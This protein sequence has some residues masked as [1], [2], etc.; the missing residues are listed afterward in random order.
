MVNNSYNRIRSVKLGTR[1]EMTRTS[2]N[3]RLNQLSQVT[4]TVG[5]SLSVLQTRVLKAQ[6]IQVK[7]SI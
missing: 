2:Y 6:V 7:K 3:G 4:E 1:E 5:G